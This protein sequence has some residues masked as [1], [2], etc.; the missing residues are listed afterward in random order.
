MWM[1]NALLCFVWLAAVVVATSLVGTFT[2]YV[3]IY[4]VVKRHKKQ[5]Q[6]QMAAQM[7]LVEISRLKRLRKSAVN[8]L[9]VFFVFML[10]YLPFF[11]AAAINN[12]SSSSNKTVILAYEFSLTLMLSNSTL[13]PLMYCLRLREFR[14][15]VKKTYRRLF[16]LEP[17]DE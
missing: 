11:V 15:A 3:K 10:C 5:I 1:M 6:D 4:Q 9:Y 17:A 2:V 13:N 16:C 14:G 7:S 8:T 12:M